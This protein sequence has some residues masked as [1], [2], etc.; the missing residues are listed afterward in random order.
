VK[1]RLR[2]REISEA[3]LNHWRGAVPN[4]RIGHL[5]REAGRACAR[6]LQL[7]LA[8][9]AV[10]YGHWTFLTILWEEDGLTQT[11]LSVQAGVMTSTTVT[12]LRAMEK[13]GY[14]VRTRSPSNR[15]NVYVHLT[16]KGKALKRKLSPL[17][18]EVNRVAVRGVRPSDVGVTRKTLHAIID[19]LRQ[20]ELA[21]TNSK[22]RVLSTQELSRLISNGGSS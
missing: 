3:M 6:A 13:L 9:Y 4:D 16:P 5:V 1:T 19:N 11:E 2:D 22:R 17:R 15:K 12:A 14:V 20:D 18:D 21:T 10:P 7:R 8:E